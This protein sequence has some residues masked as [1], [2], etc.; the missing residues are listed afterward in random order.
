[1]I[2]WLKVNNNSEFAVLTQLPNQAVEPYVIAPIL[3]VIFVTPGFTSLEQI[4]VYLLILL[5]KLLIM[6]IRLRVAIAHCSAVSFDVTAFCPILISPNK[7]CTRHC[8]CF[9][10]E[11]I[12]I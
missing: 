10:I 1:M 4:L 8:Y 6:R 12:L 2:K 5:S 9:P 11:M 3:T 7:A